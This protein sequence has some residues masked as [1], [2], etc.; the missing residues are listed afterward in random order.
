MF[1]L[2]VY[3]SGKSKGTRLWISACK[4]GHLQCSCMASPAKNRP[5]LHINTVDG[6]MSVHLILPML[7][8]LPWHLTLWCIDFRPYFMNDA[9]SISVC[10]T[11]SLNTYF[12]AFHAADVKLKPLFSAV[13]CLNGEKTPL[14]CFQQCCVSM[15]FEI[16]QSIFTVMSLI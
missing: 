16:S 9:W 10:P 8:P 12:A 3:S 5:N 4:L 11:Q 6:M 1:H 7:D 2:L 14:Y 13:R 15:V